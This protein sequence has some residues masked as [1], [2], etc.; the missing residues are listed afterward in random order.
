MKHVREREKEE[1]ERVKG[2]Y[3]A[4]AGEEGKRRGSQRQLD[5]ESW[6]G[7]ISPYYSL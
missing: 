1:K 2:V 5:V 4:R 6:G 3:G 7:K